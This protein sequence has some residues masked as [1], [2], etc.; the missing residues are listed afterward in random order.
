MTWKKHGK[1]MSK[2]SAKPVKNKENVSSVRSILAALGIG[3]LAQY[4]LARDSLLL[5]LVGYGVA[6]WFFVSR[7]GRYLEVDSPKDSR[8]FELKL[9]RDEL[10]G[11]SKALVFIRNNWR[12]LTIA[13]ILSGS[14][15]LS[16]DKKAEQ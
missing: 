6:V 8:G 12:H 14:Y 4:A 16:D 3:G 2:Q 7:L 9:L 13:E 15:K 10:R 11:K 5:G 1:Q